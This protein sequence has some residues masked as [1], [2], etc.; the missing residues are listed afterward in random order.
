MAA[1][2]WM[3]LLLLLLCPPAWHGLHHRAPC[4]SALDSEEEEEDDGSQKNIV[5]A[6]IGDDPTG[7]V[8]P[9]LDLLASGPD[10][11]LVN[12][13]LPGETPEK[14]PD[15]PGLHPNISRELPT[16]GGEA[17]AAANGTPG[18][19]GL[20]QNASEE[21][22]EGGLGCDHRGLPVQT[23]RKATAKIARGMLRLGT[24]LLREM[25]REDTGG[26]LF[27]SPLSV[28]LALAHLALGAA[29][30]TEKQ[31]L[32]VLHAESVPCLHQAL[33]W[34]SQHLS[35]TELSLAG[36]LYLQKGFPVKE[37][38]LEDSERFYRAKPAT[39]SGNSEADLEAINNWVKE[40]TGGQIPSML[41]ELPADAVMVLLNAVHF[42]GFWKT[43]FDPLLT[44]LS[45]FHLDEEFTVPVEMMTA[46][47]YPL[48]WFTVDAL[49][50]QVARFP[51]KGNTSFVAVVP[52]HFE[53][54]FSQLLEQLH[55]AGPGHP[56]PKEKPTLVKMPRLRLR[57]HLDLRQALSRLGLGELFSA[58]DL[59]PMAEGPLLVSSIQ[60]QAA[61]ELAEAGVEASAATSVAMSRSLSAFHLNRP[62]AFFIFDDAS[63]IPLFLG[64]IR[65]PDPSGPRQRK[66]GDCPPAESKESSQQPC[67]RDEAEKP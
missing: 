34:I 21:A 32:E 47:V 61:L 7:E 52:N 3:L 40:A 44:E 41:S 8:P 9:R 39:L 24:D 65:N 1:L 45:P 59:R 42:R 66:M 2:P 63:G 48:S 60:H 49:D 4:A 22:A 26:N 36:R 20:P 56:F 18:G 57:H 25:E 62:F 28:S 50:V 46:Q 54:N 53:G 35:R 55:G 15:S 51:F 31:L 5:L 38:F 13:T 23:T 17:S 64:T 6:F 27:F 19:Q 10:L 58:P 33:G 16:A 11:L 14:G 43:K 67:A 29:N 37:K 12:T 30:Q